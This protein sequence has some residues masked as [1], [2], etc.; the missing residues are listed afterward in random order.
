MIATVAAVLLLAFAV[1]LLRQAIMRHG[2]FAPLVTPLAAPVAPGSTPPG[3]T[4]A[5]PAATG[6]GP[7]VAALRKHR[8]LR[9]SLSL[10]S[11]ALLAGAVGVL[12]YP[13]YTNLYQDRVQDRLDDQLASPELKQAYQQGA[14]AVGDGL[15]R[16]KIPKIGLDMV[17][18]EG[19]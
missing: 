19:T 16:I 3:S 13:F 2:P 15:T 9:R 5:R 17:V 10:L 11:V 6:G 12:G 14:V 8:W 7:V 18:V 1:A 4:A